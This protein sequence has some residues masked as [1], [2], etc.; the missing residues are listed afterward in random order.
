MKNR[1][2]VTYIMLAIL[3]GALV[4]LAFYRQATAAGC[5]Y[6]SV[7][8]YHGNSASFTGTTKMSDKGCIYGKYSHGSC[9]HWA[10]CYCP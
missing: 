9:E 2:V 3:W 5:S 10:L 6:S 4:I 7:C 8:P 1:N